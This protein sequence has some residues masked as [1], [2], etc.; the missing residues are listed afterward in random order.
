[1]KPHLVYIDPTGPMIHYG[2]GFMTI[3]DLNPQT[4]LRWRMSRREAFCVALR[5]TWAA[6]RGG[7]DA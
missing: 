1:M 2:A 6:L 7:P 4:A 3:E 5:L